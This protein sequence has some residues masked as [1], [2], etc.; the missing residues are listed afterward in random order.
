LG[1]ATIPVILGL[2]PPLDRLTLP[3]F[4]VPNL[5][6]PEQKVVACF[7]ATDQQTV[8]HPDVDI[9]AIISKQPSTQDHADVG[10]SAANIKPAQYYEYVDDFYE[11]IRIWVKLSQSIKSLTPEITVQLFEYSFNEIP[12]S[13]H[14][15][16][17][18]PDGIPPAAPCQIS[19]SYTFHDYADNELLPD[20]K[21]SP[22]WKLYLDDRKSFEAY[23]KAANDERL[24][25]GLYTAAYLA[26][27]AASNAANE[28]ITKLGGQP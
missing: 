5:E 26:C 19:S 1:F 18:R 24:R 28:W 16:E 22:V 9:A 12:Y 6:Q 3:I 4:R 7:D 17:K 2:P 10:I 11:D 15:G 21:S 20:I 14:P 23:V 25:I 27:A 13:W 8:D